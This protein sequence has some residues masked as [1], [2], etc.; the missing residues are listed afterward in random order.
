MMD[1]SRST[2]VERAG[3]A[4]LV[5]FTVVTVLGYGVFA[6]HPQRLT[7]VPYGPEFFAISFRFFA[8]VHILLCAAVLGIVLVG[9][10]GLRWAPALLAVCAVSFT[11]EH[12]GTGYGIPFGGYGYTTLLGPRIGPRVPALIP[13]SWFLMSLPAWV[14][15]RSVFPG[16]GAGRIVLGALGLVIWDLA[17]DPAMSFLTTYWRWEETGP[18]Y[19]MP[20]LNLVGWFATGV[21]LMSLLEVLA[22]DGRFDP[23]PAPLMA[24][25]YGAVLS[26]PLGMLGAAGSW[27]AVVTTVAALAAVASGARALSRR[28]AA[29]GP[30]A[31]AGTSTPSPVGAS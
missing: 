2:R 25:Y 6:L 5:A 23:L 31:T 30:D 15:A 17:L 24:A 28:L 1:T 9:R 22:R 29:A 20:W 12:I 3:L 13:L 7:D 8:Q 10:T 4:V 11:A 18:Y 26:L 21:V 19:G 16:T 27:L 14:V